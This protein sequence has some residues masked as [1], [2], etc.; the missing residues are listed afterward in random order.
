MTVTTKLTV[1][2]YISLST[3][4]ETAGQS[5]RT[6]RRRISDGSLPAYRFG[7]A[8]DPGPRG[9]RASPRPADPDGGLSLR[10]TPCAR[11][12]PRGAARSRH[13]GQRPRAGSAG[14]PEVEWPRRPI[15]SARVAPLWAA[16]PPPGQPGSPAPGPGEDHVT[17]LPERHTE[18]M[19]LSYL[20]RLSALGPCVLTLALTSCAAPDAFGTSDTAQW[21][22][23]AENFVETPAEIACVESVMHDLLSDDELEEW[24]SRDPETIT[25]EEIQ[26]LPHAID[27]ADRCR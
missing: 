26:A 22:R 3:A 25:V 9:G 11:P 12:V 27:M 8:P 18:L 1:P 15:S 7:P 19:R 5:V 14:P 2:H 20:R 6:L 24:L 16:H 4:A 21:L 17:S 23:I 13:R 10:P